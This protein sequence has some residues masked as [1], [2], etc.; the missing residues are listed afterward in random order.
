MSLFLELIKIKEIEIKKSFEG[1]S[2]Q[3]RHLEF[4]KKVANT[5]ENFTKLNITIFSKS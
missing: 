2:S 1:F 5:T 4:E 3:V